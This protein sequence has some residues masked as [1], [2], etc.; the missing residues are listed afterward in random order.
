MSLISNLPNYDSE[1][2]LF[3]LSFPNNQT[4]GRMFQ[5]AFEMV[6]G[7]Y[8]M[9]SFKKVS[10]C[11]GSTHDLASLTTDDIQYL[12]IST[13]LHSRYRPSLCNPAPSVHAPPAA[14]PALQVEVMLA[15]CKTPV[16]ASGILFTASPRMSSQISQHPPLH[17]LSAIHPA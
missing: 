1:C 10:D 13:Q 14:Y 8:M 4:S 6:N 3:E 17:V 16:G 7:V 9:S 15:L 12:L 11:Q 2:I 5:L